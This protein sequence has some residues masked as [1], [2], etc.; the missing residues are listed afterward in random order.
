MNR[1]TLLEMIS[2][3]KQQRDELALKVHLGKKEAQDEWKELTA[4]LDEL[5]AKLE[6]VKDAAQETGSNLFASFKQVAE[7]VRDGFV[8][9]K[10]SLPKS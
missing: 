1:E 4:K 5:N 2:A 9:I 10:D 6:P 8:R 3:L 7:E